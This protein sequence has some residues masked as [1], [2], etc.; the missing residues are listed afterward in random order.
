MFLKDANNRQNFIH[1]NWDAMLMT[2]K[3]SALASPDEQETW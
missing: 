3:T 1:F 2:F